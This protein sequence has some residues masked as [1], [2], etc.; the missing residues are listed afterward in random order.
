[1]SMLAVVVQ[2]DR[3]VKV[4]QKPIPSLKGASSLYSALADT[5]D[6]HLLGADD[7]VLVKLVCIGQNPTD[8]VHADMI[9]K[10]GKLRSACVR[11]VIS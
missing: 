7:E 9:A 1:M 8:Q 11:P 2:Q 5:A 6:A 10:P 4:E 3:S